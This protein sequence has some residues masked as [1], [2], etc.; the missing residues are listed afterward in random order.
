MRASTRLPH[1]IL[2]KTSNVLDAKLADLFEQLTLVESM[3]LV[4]LV[5]I[6][7]SRILDSSY[8]SK[9]ADMA[10]CYGA[11]P[12]DTGN[13]TL[14]NATARN[15]AKPCGTRSQP[16][17]YDPESGVQTCCIGDTQCG[18][19]SICKWSGTEGQPSLGSG[20]YMS[21]CTDPTFQSPLCNRACQKY[22]F[23]SDIVF[24]RDGVWACC[25]KTT[26]GTNEPNCSAPLLGQAY[27]LGWSPDQFPGPINAVYTLAASTTI[28]QATS[29]TSSSSS[30]TST[31]PATSA[32]TRIAAIT[33]ATADSTAITNSIAPI[34]TGIGT[35]AKAGIGVGVALGALAL[36]SLA[37]F[38][39]L[40]RRQRQTRSAQSPIDVAVENNVATTTGLTS[41]T[42]N[43]SMKNEMSATKPL[44]EL[45]DLPRRYELQADT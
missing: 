14:F 36:V 28:A 8:H 30:I 41:M 15:G 26:D 43:V 35:G 11:L 13:S 44:N 18:A 4:L 21:T 10:T 3:T 29:S 34:H 12:G 1:D 5:L 45:P 31:T 7:V 9:L 6:K 37:T 38:W 27:N 19:N 33:T 32:I 20:Y 23:G 22:A 39:V 25:G 2:Y 16:G 24:V 17:L 42:H 40:R